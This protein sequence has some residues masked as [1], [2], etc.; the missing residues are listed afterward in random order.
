MRSVATIFMLFF[1]LNLTAQDFFRGNFDKSKSYILLANPTA[2][3][4]E[5]VKFLTENKLLKLNS[6]KV[7]F[8]GV[9]HE[10]QLYDFN[11]TIEYIRESKG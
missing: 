7:H 5:T 6:G 8:V 9:Y 11:E 2:R 4:I 3:N 10:N 1:L